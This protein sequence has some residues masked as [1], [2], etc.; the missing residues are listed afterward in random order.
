LLVAIPIPVAVTLRDP[1]PTFRRADPKNERGDVDVWGVLV[2]VLV[3]D[4]GG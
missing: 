2:L 1:A 3:L 4:H